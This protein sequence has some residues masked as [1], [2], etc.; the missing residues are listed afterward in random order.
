MIVAGFAGTAAA[1]SSAE[2]KV[3]PAGCNCR[4]GNGGGAVMMPAPVET[5]F[6]NPVPGFAPGHDG[7]AGGVGAAPTV[8]MPAQTANLP[9]GTIGRTYLR[10]SAPVPAVKHPRAG[11]IDVHAKDAT[12]VSVQWT[13]PY[14]LTDELDGFVDAKDKDV[15]HFEE[16]QMLPGVPYIVRVEARYGTEEKPRYEERYARL[17]MG[18]IV[19]ISFDE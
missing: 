13:H 16:K 8:V 19:S 4:G 15:F 7:W 5:P 9:P 18:R 10:P 2:S 14:R 1:V 17:I 3:T 11:L 6:L 12:S